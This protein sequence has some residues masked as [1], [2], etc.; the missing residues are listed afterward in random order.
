M[1]RA[2]RPAWALVVLAALLTACTGS[3]PIPSRT[4]PSSATPSPGAGQSGTPSASDRS[5]RHPIASQAT[6]SPTDGP[7]FPRRTASPF[8]GL[9]GASPTATPFSGSGPSASP[10]AISTP[11]P[12]G[13]GADILVF[14][15]DFSD[16]ESGFP[17]GD[18]DEQSVTYARGGLILQLRSAGQ[19]IWSTRALQAVSD[20]PVVRL[21]GRIERLSDATSSGYYGLVCGRDNETYHAALL[22]TGGGY[23]VLRVVDGQSTVIA[24]DE[25]PIAGLPSTGPVDMAIECVAGEGASAASVT[26]EVQGQLV[27]AITDEPGLVTL[28]RAGVYAESAADGDGFRILAD[29]LVAHVGLAAGP[30]PSSSPVATPVDPALDALLRHV[31]AAIRGSCAQAPVGG[32]GAFVS[33]LCQPGGG[34]ESV[35]YTQYVSQTLMQAAYSV[36]LSTYGAGATGSSC[37]TGPAHGPYSVEGLPAGQVLCF[38]HLGRAWVEWTD[39][40]L[41]ILAAANRID[42]SF[43]ELYGWW[44]DAGPVR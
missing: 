21:E 39:E 37:E 30:P 6:E 25:T 19:S 29:D 32:G 28:R 12:P 24:R 22:Y 34:I 36:D 7:V 27:A 33:V 15:D 2:G 3:I 9:P 42:E 1:T 40:R 17:T 5:T 20:W 10:G 18:F 23:V 26:L 14:S 35:R 38:S 4:P 31:P 43:A 13:G 41:D 16:P 44:V 11:V 8:P